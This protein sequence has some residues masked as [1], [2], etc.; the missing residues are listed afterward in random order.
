MNEESD[1]YEK[2]NTSKYMPIINRIESALEKIN[3]TKGFYGWT[4][5]GH[6]GIRL[7]IRLD[8][9]LEEYLI[10]LDE[11]LSVLNFFKK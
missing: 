1:K 9:T 8:T 6:E 10:K 7:E 4:E 5:I 2:S 3:D 11:Y